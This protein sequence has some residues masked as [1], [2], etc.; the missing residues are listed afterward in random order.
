MTLVLTDNEGRLERDAPNWQARSAITLRPGRWLMRNG[1]IAVVKTTQTFDGYHASDRKPARF[2]AWFGHSEA[3]G[4][5]LSWNANGTY[6]AH[7]RDEFDIVG[8][9]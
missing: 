7:A 9:A 5:G 6:G 3:T 1:Q 2:V 8:A 4:E